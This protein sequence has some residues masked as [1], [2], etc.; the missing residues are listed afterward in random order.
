MDTE[1]LF[2]EHNEEN[3][4]TSSGE[5]TNTSS[6]NQDDLKNPLTGE[7]R[8]SEEQIEKDLGDMEENSGFPPGGGQPFSG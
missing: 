3:R 2:P 5:R 6:D 1:K 4:G 7:T 8:R